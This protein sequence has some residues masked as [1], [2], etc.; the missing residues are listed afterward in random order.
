MFN[1]IYYHCLFIYLLKKKNLCVCVPHLSRWLWFF[2]GDI[3]LW[4]WGGG[5]GWH[6]PTAVPLVSLPQGE[7]TGTITNNKQNNNNTK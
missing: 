6:L 1:C 2:L 3:R 5:A 7:T 4:G